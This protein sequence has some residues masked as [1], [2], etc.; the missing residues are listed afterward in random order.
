MVIWNLH[1]LCVTF[2]PLFAA[3]VK[4]GGLPQAS[5]RDFLK[6]RFQKESASLFNPS[7]R[8]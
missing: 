1:R 7:V 6:N 8:S 2:N 4:G 3:L 5:R